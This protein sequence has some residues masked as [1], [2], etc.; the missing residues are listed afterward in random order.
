MKK[1]FLLLLL[2]TLLP[3]AGWA[4]VDVVVSSDYT[5]TLDKK[6]MVAGE[7]APTVV[8]INDAITGFTVLGV[9]GADKTTSVD[10]DY[11]ADGDMGNYYMKVF[12]DNKY[13]FVP[14]KLVKVADPTLYNIVCDEDS[15]NAS[16]ENGGLKN[17]YS[18]FDGEGKHYD[19]GWWHGNNS[20]LFT[21]MWDGEDMNGEWAQNFSR[22][23]LTAVNCIDRSW[24]ERTSNGNAEVLKINSDDDDAAVY[25]ALANARQA[26]P[27]APLMSDT[28]K[29]EG[30][31]WVVFYC[32]EDE[33][34]AHTFGFYYKNGDVE[35]YDD[36]SGYSISNEKRFMT[37]AGL[38]EGLGY[39]LALPV[40]NITG[41]IASSW[42]DL[43]EN[44]FEYDEIE[45]ND[46]NDLRYTFVNTTIYELP[47]G[48]D[49][50]AVV[51]DATVNSWTRTPGY[52][53]YIGEEIE[54][55]VKVNGDY[56][57]DTPY[58]VQ[59]T[60][61]DPADES[62]DPVVVDGPLHVGTYTMTLGIEGVDGNFVAVSEE[63][64]SFT[65]NPNTLEIVLQQIYMP[66]GSDISELTPKYVLKKAAEDVT[67]TDQ[68]VVED[69]GEVAQGSNWTDETLT[70]GKVRNYTTLGEPRGFVGRTYKQIEKVIVGDANQDESAAQE[71]EYET[72][73]DFPGYEDYIATTNT[74]S[75]NVVG[76]KGE[77]TVTIE[78][79]DLFKVYGF[80]DPTFT[81]T[82][83]NQSGNPVE[84]VTVTR[85]EA[86]TEE[87]ETVGEHPLTVNIDAVKANYN[88]TVN[89]EDPKLTIT[90]FDLSLDNDEQG[91]YGEG[92]ENYKPMFNIEVLPVTYNADTQFPDAKITFRSEALNKTID[93][94]YEEDGTTPKVP[95]VKKWHE[96][97]DESE[98][99]IYTTENYEYMKGASNYTYTDVARKGSY[100]PNVKAVKRNAETAAIEE[101]AAI[102]VEGKGAFINK[103]TQTYAIQP[104][105]LSVKVK[106][107]EGEWPGAGYNFG[108]ELNTEGENG[109]W[110]EKEAATVRQQILNAI[111]EAVT[112]Y[113]PDGEYGYDYA[114]GTG[115]ITVK[116]IEAAQTA[117]NV[118]LAASNYDLDFAGGAANIS[119]VTL[120]I[121]PNDQN[122]TYKVFDGETEITDLSNYSK[123]YTYK[124]PELDQNAYKVM[125]GETVVTLPEGV[126]V[127]LTV[128]GT[129]VGDQNVISASVS[130]V[131]ANFTITATATAKFTVAKLEEIHLAYNEVAQVL[132][133][134][135]GQ[136]GIKVFMPNRNLKNKNW[137]TMVLPFDID[138]EEL[139]DKTAG[140]GYG[141]FETLNEENNSVNPSF[142]LT[143]GEIEANTPFIIKDRY[144]WAKNT[145]K[146]D[147]DKGY[148]ASISFEDK[149]IAAL[150][151]GFAYNDLAKAPY[152][153]DAYGTKFIGQYTG[154]TGVADNERWMSKGE[155]YKGTAETYLDP[156][157][158]FLS[159]KT[160]EE[161]ESA[162]VF[163]EEVEGFASEIDEISAEAAGA[164][165]WYTVNGMKL[166]AAPIQ[167]GAYIKDGKK[168]YVK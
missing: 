133:D 110:P 117:L 69:L 93:L 39:P 5:V 124:R 120:A 157:V 49:L 60:W 72:V 90:E 42:M 85:P 121:V 125:S 79:D 40:D 162:R 37:V 61:D 3:L 17:Y 95:F 20:N 168:V 38:F 52:A 81:F 107:F 104:A 41:A 153:Q 65:V 113:D 100:V 156:T 33:Q 36:V 141:A 111:G 131:P 26:D 94:T 28:W 32:G 50:E 105:K 122:G 8:K 83:I 136:E 54:P 15:W 147:A 143:I 2:M 10:V 96:G 159:F 62:E 116:V 129:K 146:K 14:F 118:V 135:Q 152:K 149:T 6:W 68:I 55:V 112:A 30:Y 43:Q 13:L 1:S 84:G 58:T 106:G 57:Y 75:A 73:V 45:S 123:V 63:T 74:S 164:E 151:E 82:A 127:T 44:V 99:G 31:P 86:G 101:G 70:P 29:K 163:I 166:N 23:W 77:L 89:P 9:Y 102:I 150:P 92:K 67:P 76:K 7:A 109:A 16:Y 140:L 12:Y 35:A 46:D 128:D 160:A 142:K 59:Y 80:A 145:N 155:F 71:P 165:G 154:K 130:N 24:P 53:T 21:K 51:E 144:D 48:D 126:K 114:G 98:S 25:Q 161:A 134:H 132:E 148:L 4:N 87:G 119:N 56:L 66:F 88:V 103:K 34:N 158:A 11:F 138:A 139:F 91:G 108:I 64:K 115:N 78:E 19:Y 137:Y 27:A 97:G 18:H 47:V 167:K 22:T